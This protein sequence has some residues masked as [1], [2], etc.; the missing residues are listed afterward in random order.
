MDLQSFAALVSSEA[1]ARRF[2]VALCQENEGLVCPRCWQ[3]K[4]YRLGDGR[5][6][7]R[8]C[9]YTFHEFTGRFLKGCAFDCRQWLW[10]LKLFELALPPKEIATQ[11]G[12]G[13][14]LALRAQDV[15]RRAIVAL[16]LDA[17]ALYR[18]GVSPGSGMGRRRPPPEESPVFG[19]IDIKGEII[20]DVVPAYDAATILH[21]KNNFRLQ[22]GSVGGVVYT[23]PIRK[24]RSLVGCGPAFWPTRLVQHGASR[25]AVESLPFWDYAKKL[26]AKQRGMTADTFPLILKEAEFRYNHRNQALL[27]ALAPL[28]CR[29]I[30]R[31]ASHSPGADADGEGRLS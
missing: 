28:A 2:F 12:I 14:E 29:R 27:D 19:V 11:M 15:V 23:A 9:G 31:P 26:F 4:P 5:L 25:L 30:P 18:M 24:Y 7:C 6:R 10:F 13:Y 20:C 8:N 1:K 22:T 17:D 21:Y 16:A 3:A